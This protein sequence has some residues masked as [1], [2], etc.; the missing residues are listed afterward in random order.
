MDN[1]RHSKLQQLQKAKQDTVSIQDKLQ[2]ALLSANALKTGNDLKFLTGYSDMQNMLDDVLQE[3]TKWS[4]GLESMP[5]LDIPITFQP[6][7]AEAVL[8]YGRVGDM[9]GRFYCSVVN[10]P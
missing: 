6:Y 10:V 1:A 4:D 9:L 7:A 5:T 8:S 2:T 3:G